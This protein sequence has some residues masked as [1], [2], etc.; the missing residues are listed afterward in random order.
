MRSNEV[1]LKR[2]FIE[3][4]AGMSLAIEL[5]HSIAACT[6]IVILGPYITKY[7]L[8]WLLCGSCIYIG[9]VEFIKKRRSMTTN[10]AT[11]G[12]GK[13]NK[14]V[15]FGRADESYQRKFYSFRDNTKRKKLRKFSVL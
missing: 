11:N 9:I 4:F 1:L 8:F 3:W 12:Y 13:K 2:A 14:D 7:Y 10:G 15:L 6:L 5:S